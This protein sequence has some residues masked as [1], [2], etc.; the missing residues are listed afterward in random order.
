L[1]SSRV[2]YHCGLIPGIVFAGTYRTAAGRNAAWGFGGTGAVV[3]GGTA[4][5]RESVPS[6]ERQHPSES[7]VNLRLVCF[8]RPGTPLCLTL[9]GYLDAA[10]VTT[11]ASIVPR[12]SYLLLDRLRRSMHIAHRPASVQVLDQSIFTYNRGKKEEEH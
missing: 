12:A 7:H 4:G 3:W 2:G 6:P 11:L 9:R 8:S 1:V 10:L 5:E